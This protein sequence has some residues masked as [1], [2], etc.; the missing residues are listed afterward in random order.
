MDL[1]TAL[2]T[3]GRHWRVLVLGLAVTGVVL[4]VLAVRVEQRYSATGTVIVISPGGKSNPLDVYSSS[5]SLAASVATTLGNDDASKAAVLAQGGTS[6]YTLVTDPSLPII[7]ITT[8][9]ADRGT[10]VRSFGLVLQL[11]NRLL[12][13]RQKEFA[14]PQSADL[15]VLSVTAPASAKVTAYKLVVLGIAGALG[16]LAAISLTFIA[17]SATGRRRGRA[18][19]QEA[20]P[21]TPLTSEGLSRHT[22]PE[23]DISPLSASQPTPAR[24]SDPKPDA[25]PTPLQRPEPRARPSPPKEVPTFADFLAGQAVTPPPPTEQQSP[26]APL[27]GGKA[28]APASPKGA[29][30]AGARQRRP[31]TK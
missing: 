25:E 26:E 12:A 19:V 11:M 28:P 29:G 8:T 13:D 20:T 5:S 23:R 2:R 22:E 17:E 6:D 9:S 4:A 3:V 14:T 7:T 15:Q 24:I 10:A 16:A 31:R 30:A 21:A 1:W 18:Q 27:H